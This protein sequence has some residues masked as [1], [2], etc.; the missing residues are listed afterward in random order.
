MKVNNSIGIAVIIFAAAVLLLATEGVSIIKDLIVAS[1]PQA[2]IN[3]LVFLIENETETIDG[4]LKWEKELDERGLIALIKAEK[5]VLEKYS[6]VFRALLE[7]GYEIAIG[8]SEKPCWDLP[9]EEQYQVMKEYL[10]FGEGLLGQRPRVFSC[11]YFSY[12]ENTLQAADALGVEYL[13]ARG[14]Q[15]GRAV[16]YEP[17]E[18]EVKLISVSNVEFGEMGSGSL[19]D[20]SLWSRGATGQEFEE[21]FLETLAEKPD[22]L[23]FVSHAHLGGTKKE[24][25]QAYENALSSDKVVWRSFEDWLAKA[26]HLEMPNSDVPVNREVKYVQPQP[27]VAMEDLEP[28]EELKGKIVIFHNGR[29]EM[30]L[31]ALEF[32]ETID[33]PVEEY[34]ESEAGF[35]EKLLALARDYQTSEGLSDSFQ[36]FP[37][38]LA[39]N[40]VFSGFNE[41]I[42]A[43]ILKLVE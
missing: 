36:F 28:I 19:C 40:R 14:T 32:L 18:Y 37:L 42:K 27:A 11:R 29:G 34:L 4:V 20:V 7:K 10:D 9:Y 1:K 21:K 24:W 6:S 33:Y 12:D 23:I 17:E 25:W 13:L 2:K 38:I 8:Y 30:C 3:G 41:S 39:G 15:G 43:E 31:Q 16:I 35:N 22:S 5:E 26:A